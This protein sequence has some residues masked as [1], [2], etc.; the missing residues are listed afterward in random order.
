MHS[1]PWA[2]RVQGMNGKAEVFLVGGFL[3][4]TLEGNTSTCY[5]EATFRRLLC[6]FHQNPAQFFVRLAC[7]G[8]LNTGP[9]GGPCCSG[10]VY[11]IASGAVQPGAH[12]GL[13]LIINWPQAILTA[14]SERVS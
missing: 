11:D 9:G 14:I 4:A 13:P 1:K 8:H 3:D 10:A 7:V 6:A 5:G 2:G 12:C